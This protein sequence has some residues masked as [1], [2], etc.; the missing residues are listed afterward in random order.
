MRTVPGR[1]A[2]DAFVRVSPRDARYFELSDGRPFVPIGLNLIH[3]SGPDATETAAGL[4]LMERWMEA[5]AG[6]GGN[7]IRV[8]ASHSFWDVE[9]GRAGVYDEAKAAERLDRVFAAARKHGLRV[10]VTLEHFRDVD[11]E[12]TAKTWSMK[13]LHHVSRGGTAASMAD[14]MT[15]RASRAQFVGKIEWC[16]RRYGARPEVFGWELWNEMNAV[17]AGGVEAWTAPMLS[18]LHRV[19]PRNLAMQ[20]LGSFDTADKRAIYRAVA[21]MP[22]ND[23]A[24]VHRYLDLGAKIELCRGP[25]DVLAA[26]AVRE[27][28]AMRPGR[29]VLL[30]ESG[31]VG[32]YEKRGHTGPFFLYGKDKDGMI[33]H[34]VLFAPFFAGA[35]GPGHCWH[36]DSYVAANGLWRHF[37]RFAAAVRDI[38]PAA[39]AF[40]PAMVAHPRLRVYL[41]KGRHTS[42]L[43]CRDSAN[44]WKTELE[45]GRAP[46]SVCGA[47]LDLPAL[48]RAEPPLTATVYDPWSDV[49]VPAAIRAGQIELPGF[50]RSVVVRVGRTE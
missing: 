46:E 10:K 30:A 11:P 44:T 32:S 26:D 6:N 19:F 41:L 17:R 48:G 7:F 28:L 12:S 18:E 22:G 5:L 3:P 49:S 29:P 47:R 25:V 20:S 23:V 16:G 40:E 35:A 31:G 42:L 34:D 14:W 50:R 45:E 43:W 13:A 38:D 24:Q 36:W 37:A 1:A 27:L 9:H 2:S 21:T 39:E 8:W 15:N 4:A 33:L